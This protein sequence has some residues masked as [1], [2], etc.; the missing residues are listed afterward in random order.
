VLSAARVGS[1][2]GRSVDVVALLLVSTPVLVAAYASRAL[3]GVELRWLPVAG[4][5]SG[6][7][8]Y[9]LPVLS[10]AALSTGYLVL[11]V[12]DELLV[13]MRAP[14]VK[15]AAA[16][17]IPS[18]KLHSVH[19]LR[20]SLIP[21]AAYVAGNLGTLVTGLIIVEGVF[22]VPGVGGLLFTAIAD[23]DRSLVVG[24]ATF[25]AIVVIVANALAD[26]V[27]ALLDPRVR[28]G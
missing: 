28:L 12:K 23:Q 18:W 16:R 13:A 2:L 11:L 8:A 17:G 20:P 7:E 10:L 6:P 24:V 4:L 25:V 3:F 26:L 27:V 9:V 5:G 21:A 22:R 14:Y 15:A 19:A 1:R